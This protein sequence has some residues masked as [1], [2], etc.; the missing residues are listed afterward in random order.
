M[1]RVMKHAVLASIV[2]AL[3]TLISSAFR[4]SFEI[5]IGGHFFSFYGFPFPFYEVAVQDLLGTFRYFFILNAFGDFIIW[6]GI[7]FTFMIALNRV[8]TRQ[9]HHPKLNSFPN[10]AKAPLD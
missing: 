3:I 9:N 4:T 8:L 5:V 2:G 10:R 7:S 6:F 1:N